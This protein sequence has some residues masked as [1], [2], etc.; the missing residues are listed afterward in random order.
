MINDKIQKLEKI[1]LESKLGKKDSFSEFR[2][3]IRPLIK[4]IFDA[5]LKKIP[6]IE[7]RRIE[8]D[9]NLY[10]SIWSILNSYDFNDAPFFYEL[11][12]KI[13][14]NI[15]DFLKNETSI[16]KKKIPTRQDINL[17]I[18]RKNNPKTK[19][20]YYGLKSLTLKQLQV[21]DMNVYKGLRTFKIAEIIKIHERKVELRLAFAYRNIKKVFYGKKTSS[22]KK[23][24]YKERS[25]RLPD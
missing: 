18:R 22:K 3:I 19:K 17:M 25:L 1:M 20:I 4:D 23:V 9:Q 5:F 24:L 16:S 8:I 7:Y 21:I 11:K 10:L 14:E 12:Q 13:T 6:E 15:I 2:R